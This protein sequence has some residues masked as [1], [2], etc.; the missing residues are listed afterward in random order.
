[1][2]TMLT[3]EEKTKFAL[4]CEENAHDTKSIIEQMRK[5]NVPEMAIKHFQ[6]EIACLEMVAK[7]LRSTETQSISRS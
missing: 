7:R 5:I 2:A 3:D 1:M 6:I 4:W